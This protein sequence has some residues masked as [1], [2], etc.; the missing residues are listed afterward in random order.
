MPLQNATAT[1]AGAAVVTATAKVHA[2]AAVAL[3]AG[4]TFGP[5][6]TAQHKA[7]S[8]LAG[9]STVTAAPVDHD[10]PFATMAGVSTLTAGG[11]IFRLTGA[12]LV[13]TGIF[14]IDPT[15]VIVTSFFTQRAFQPNSFQQSPRQSVPGFQ[16]SSVSVG[17]TRKSP[18]SNTG[19]V[20]VTSTVPAGTRKR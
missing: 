18:S 13:G 6:G 8:S 10:H 9:L 12:S 5:A 16:Q 17:I 19:G 2:A 20:P 3:A 14:F 15:K 1:L 7:V 11:H 4:A